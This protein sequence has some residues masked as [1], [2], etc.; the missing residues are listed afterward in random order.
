M[1]N[2]DKVYFDQ[3]LDDIKIV[4]KAIKIAK[5]EHNPFNR[6]YACN[7]VND[8]LLRLSRDVTESL[9]SLIQQDYERLLF[10]IDIIKDGVQIMRDEN[11]INNRN[12]ACS[13]IEKLVNKLYNDIQEMT[14][15]RKDS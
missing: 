1:S 10:D 8:L 11:N 5:D 12:F 9:P 7:L 15:I 6:V 13:L 3:L 4:S 2:K 14:E